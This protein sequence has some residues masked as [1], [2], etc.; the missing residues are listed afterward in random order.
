MVDLSKHGIETFLREF[1]YLTAIVS[2]LKDALAVYQQYHRLPITGDVG[3]EATLAHMCQ[4]RCRCPDHPYQQ[5]QQQVMRWSKP[6]L[7]WKFV[8]YTLDIPQHQISD[9]FEKGFGVWSS[10][11]PL[12]FQEVMVDEKAD[13]EITFKNIDGQSNVL[14]QAWFPP[15]GRMEFDE[16]EAWSW[17]LPIG[18]GAVDLT[19]VVAH[20]AGHLIGLE[21]SNVQGAQMAPVYA[22]PKR[23]LENDDIRRAQQLYG[24]RS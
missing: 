3:D 1:G 2:S 12:N 6:N 4:R 20:E 15:V 22:G 5:V 24:P 9:S 21:H 17:K 11:T 10:C 19:T 13:I 8:N 23:F 18:R 14:A 16:S 7:T